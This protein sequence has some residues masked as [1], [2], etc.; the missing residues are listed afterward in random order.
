MAKKLKYISL[1]LAIILLNSKVNSLMKMYLRLMLYFFAVIYIIYPVQKNI[2]ALK[3]RR[4]FSHP[5]SER[6]LS[7]LQDCEI[8]DEELKSYIKGLDEKCEI[9]IKYKR[10]KQQPVV[11]FPLAK[12]FNETMAMD[13]KEWSHDKKI[14]LLHMVDH[15][16]KYS[17]SCVITSKKKELIVKKNFQYWMGIFG[18]TKKTLVDNGG[19]FDNTE[20][21]TLCEKFYIRIY[22]TAAES[23]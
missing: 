17:V 20:F 1:Q 10:T 13:L 12:T 15:A 11:G 22:T 23:P 21:Q 5:H 2:V 8:N 6:L 19:E 18:H 9:C 7:L 14:W 16:T 4:Q 3:L